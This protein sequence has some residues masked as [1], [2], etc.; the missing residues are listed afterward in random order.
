VERTKITPEDE[1]QHSPSETPL[2]REGYYFN[3]Y[4]PRS[5]TGI[6]IKSEIRPAIKIKQEFVSIHGKDSFLF[7]NAQQLTDDAR[8]SGSLKVEPVIP[9]QEWTITMNDTFQKVVDGI[10]AALSEKV[11]YT[12]V[13]K[14]DVPPCGYQ[15]EEGTRYEQPG[16]LEG[17]ITI[18]NTRIPF[19]GKSMRDHS[20]GLRDISTW[21][22]FYM[23]MGWHGATPLSFAYMQT[24]DTVGVIGWLRKDAYHEI[25]TVTIDPQYSGDVIDACAIQVET[26]HDHIE[27]K[28]ELIS[29]LSLSREVKG[30]KFKTIETLVALQNGYAFFWYS[31]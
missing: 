28:T 7:M 19:T 8:A 25:Q 24:E 1:Y 17:E 14:S 27:M 15:T 10:P 5:K 9:L 23:F 11:G 22:K 13:F 30:K 26:A 4:D 20:W 21:G 3:G 2:W 12:L 6:S 16:F 29:F 18:D 31:E